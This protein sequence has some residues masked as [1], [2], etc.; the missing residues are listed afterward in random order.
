M[1]VPTATK[2]R[3]DPLTVHTAEVVE[4][5]LTGSPEL[6]VATSDIPMG[7]TPERALDGVR[8]LLLANSFQLRAR[9]N[10]DAGTAFA[11]VAVT[12]DE[13]GE[14]WRKGRVNLSLQTSW[15]GRK[16][17]LCDA[18][19]DMTLHFGQLIAQ[20]AQHRPL[21]AGSLVG[22]GTVSSP[23]RVRDGRKS[24]QDLPDW[25]KGYHCI[26][27]KRAMEML[28]SGQTTTGY[29]RVGDTVEM[30][31]KGRDGHSLFGAIAQEVVSTMAAVGALSA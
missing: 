25:P 3:A 8:L 14:A 2:V 17:G 7:C 15:N 6:A 16:V 10:A 4:T 20:L 9:G 29:L 31:V 12:P 21:R 5:R 1:Q 30:D 27:E 23:A 19:P 13:L 26:A 18:G 11:P 24:A 22:S 28:Q